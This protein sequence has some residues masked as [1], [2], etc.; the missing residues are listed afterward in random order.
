MLKIISRSPSG[1]EGIEKINFYVANGPSINIEGLKNEDVVDG[2]LPLMINAYDKGDQKSF[3][4]TGS[5]TPRTIPIWIW[6]IVLV[7]V[8]W[9]IYY[10]ITSSYIQ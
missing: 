4:I 6:I 9:A 2:I 7:F 5:E 8:A 1:K 3:I 10:E